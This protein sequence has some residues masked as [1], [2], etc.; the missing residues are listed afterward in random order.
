MMTS[1]RRFLYS[2]AALTLLASVPAACAQDRYVQLEDD[3]GLLDTETGL[4]WGYNLHHTGAVLNGPGQGW[5]YTWDFAVELLIPCGAL[6]PD[7]DICTYQQFS[8]WYYDRDDTDW[9]LPTR[10]E[11]LDAVDGGIADYLDLEPGPG[12]ELVWDFSNGMAWSATEGG[13]KRGGF[14]SA[15]FVNLKTGESDRVTVGSF[16]NIVIPVRGVPAPDEGGPGNGNG[17]GNGKK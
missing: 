5:S 10:D 9:R 8:N 16:M 1:F 15:Y 12:F 14:D 4:V 2:L 3:S 11:M 13:K 17:N 7:N 6:D